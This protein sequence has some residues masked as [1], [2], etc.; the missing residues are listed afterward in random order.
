M[1]LYLDTSALVKR[2]IREAESPAVMQW[3]EGAVLSGS[4][5]IA[6]AEMAAVIGRLRRMK[7][8]GEAT[9]QHTLEVF[10]RDWPL[11]ARLAL[12]EATVARADGLAWQYALRG[13]DA[14]HLAAALRWG[15]YLGE[16][17]TLATFDR[18]LWAAARE[19]GMAVLPV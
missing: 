13:Y 11:Y 4:S 17:V 16:P 3:I 2:Y 1:I 6:R 18:Q 12:T 5:L 14:V 9:A 15:E 10:R 8:L 19:V 7:A